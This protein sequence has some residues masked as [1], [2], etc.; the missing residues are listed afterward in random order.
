MPSWDLVRSPLLAIFLIVAVD[1]LGLTIMIPLLPFYA[2][3]MGASATQVGWLIGIYAA[4]Q[5]FS[6]PLL[7]RLSDHMGRKP[8]LLVS[9]AGTFAGF[10]ITA[11]AP[12]LWVLFLARAIDGS[13]AGNL[14]LAQAYISDVTRPEDRAK[15]F[16]IIGIAFGLGFMIGPAISGLLAKY[17]YRYP[18]FAAAALS[19]TS[20]LTTYLLLPSVSPGGSRTGPSGPGGKRLS[21]VQW[22]AYV[23]YFRQPGLATRLW[24][25]LSFTFGF[26]MFVAG[27]PLVLERRLTW[28]GRPFGPEQVGYTWAFAGLLGVCLQGPALGRLVKRFGERAL[29]R[30]GFV[31]YAG[32]YAILAFCHSLPMLGLATLVTSIGGLVRPT[33]TSLITQATPREE[34]GVVLGLTQSLNSVSMIIAPPL[35]GFLIE[36]GWLTAWGLTASAV[37]LIGLMLASASTDEVRASSS[38]VSSGQVGS[39]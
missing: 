31:G 32:G 28:A 18:I 23:E 6:G 38:P 37:A 25:F 17:D 19:A 26:S 21:L 12:S 35:G 9:Q 5:L 4:C 13:T 24:Q 30:A 33:L 3:K 14:S 34:Q 1:V 27:M 8:L 10:L 16:G 36:H 20:I 22:G 29:N 15:S 2:E 11:F 39:S 7:G